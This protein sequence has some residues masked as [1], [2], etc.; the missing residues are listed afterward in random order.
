MRALVYEGNKT[1]AVRDLTIPAVEADE[2]L[3]RVAYA[4]ICGSDLLIWNGRYPRV[5]PPVTIG[6]EFS[7]VIVRTGSAVSELKAGDRVVVEPLMTCGSCHACTSGDYHLC[8][9]LGLIG[10]DTNGGM[11][12]YVKAPAAKTICIP[13]SVSLRDAALVE[14]LAVG[15]HMVNQ[16]G[17]KAGQTALVT[18]GG[19]IGLIAASVARLRGADVYVSEINPFRLEK[20]EELGFHALNA[21]DTDVVEAVRSVTGGDGAQVTFEATGTE[22]GLRDCIEAAGTKGTVLLA[23]MAKA[24]LKVDTYR[25]LAKE[26]SIVGSRVYRMDDFHEALRLMETG[27]F[28]PERFISRTV[29]LDNVVEDG[30]AAIESGAPVVKVVVDLDREQD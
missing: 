4:G 29:T 8:R 10:I 18:G 5:K 7:G 1:L 19:P 25:A 11:A 24:P 9:K 2:V 22:F 17:L 20:A 15:V 13:D 3:I 26:L 21:K 27:Q 28:V 30:F 14:P 23:G 16:S 6:H 12:Q